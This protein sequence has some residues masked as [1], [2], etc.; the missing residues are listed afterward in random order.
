MERK[1]VFKAMKGVLSILL[2]MT[3][4]VMFSQNIT[5][6]GNVVD[7][8]GEPLP[9]VTIT[10]EGSTR[11]VITDI[12]GDYSIEVNSTDA[13]TYTFVG[14]ESQTIKVGDQRTINVVMAEKIDMLDEVT[15]VAFG[16]QKK[17]S[18]LSSIA[19]IKPSELQAPTSNLTTALAGRIAGMISY[20]RSGEPGQDNADFF[21]RGV[22]TFGYKKDPLI[23][24]DGIELTSTDLSRLQVDDIASFSI[25][26]DATATALYG[27]RGANGV[28]L[29][30]TKEGTEGSKAKISARYELS[31]SSP[32][33]KT[34]WSDPI[35]YM[36]LQNEAVMTRDPLG[37]VMHS[38]QKIENTRLGL[39]PNV[40][41]AVDWYNELFKPTTLNQRANL[42]ISGG[43]NVARYYIAASVSKDEG[44]LKTSKL[45]NFNNNINLI[46]YLLR[47]NVN[48]NVTK[49]TK[50]NVRLHAT[51][52]D[53]SGPIDSGN[54][55]YK[56][57]TQTSPVLYPPYYQPDAANETTPYVLFGNYENGDYLNPYADMVKGYRDTKT[58]LMLA[59]FELSQDLGMITDGLKLRAMFNTNRRSEYGIRRSYNPYYFTAT[60]YD[61]LK[62]TY[63]LNALN[64]NSGTDYLTTSEDRKNVIT[65][66]YFE[67]ALNYD[68]TFN[69]KHG[70]SGMLVYTMRDELTSVDANNLQKSLPAR[71][72]GLAGRFTYA[73]DDRYFLEANFGYNGSERFA[74]KERFGF[75]P[76]VGLGYIISNEAFWTPELE[77]TISKLKLKATYGLVGNDAIGSSDE[78]FFYL[79]EVNMNDSD[80]SYTWGSMYNYSRNGVSIV[81]YPNENITWETSKKTNLGLELGLF[82]KWELQV[83]VYRDDRYNILMDRS[84][85]PTT[86]G[87]ST[88]IKANVGEAVS[89]GVDL[90]LDYNQYFSNNFWMSGRANFTYAHS[91][92]KVYEEPDYSLTPWRSR[93]GY[94]LSQQWGYVAERLFVDE[95]EIQNSP[96]QTFGDYLGGDI[97]YKDIN[98]DGQITSIDMVPIGYP[99]SPE[100]VYGFGASCGWKGIDA[101]F[102]FQGL[103]RE[104]FWID[105]AKVTPFV[106]TGDFS[107]NS[108]NQLLKIIEEDHWSEENRNLYAFWPRLSTTVI[109]NN[110]QRNTWFMRDGSFLRLKSVELG[111]SLPDSFIKNYHI[112]SLRIYYSGLNLLCFSKFKLWDPEMAGNGFNYP[113]QRVHNIG[114][115]LS[116]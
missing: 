111:Y 58:S 112:S 110:R 103:A 81:R 32:T 5:V 96:V 79:S 91:A 34:E 13:L 57:I 11:G 74:K 71:N 2:W 92:Y 15:V 38:P 114:I 97:K 31:V 64:P 55:L 46:K 47:S 89:K 86:M 82:N 19:T 68:Q 9:G 59:Q 26:K 99:T 10:V 52:D 14:M 25:M 104:S 116:F 56:K 48:V 33:Q 75:F 93:V 65:N 72:I 49:T 102:F 100:I 61:P 101:S 115:N 28:I 8:Q 107:Q 22:T 90:S 21:I 87:L 30:T 106:D 83:D 39:N 94:S 40:F 37:I 105:Y 66:T 45:N 77:K 18:V 85:I 76:S 1:Q 44:S 69:E 17:E 80:Y 54:T 27:A 98:G 63:I 60:N 35:T 109:N 51:M 95:K 36:H 70:V 41:P 67:T 42:N 16:T 12:D 73:Y 3:C 23:L 4:T 84:S 20:Q 29:V 113:V 53:Y 108:Q 7:E 62:D 50:A 78:R 43:G 6:R 88:G 24:I